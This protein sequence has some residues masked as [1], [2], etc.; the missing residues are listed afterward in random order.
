MRLVLSF[1]LNIIKNKKI[2]IFLHTNL[3]KIS[4]IVEKFLI[5][6]YNNIMW[7]RQKLKVWLKP[8]SALRRERNYPMLLKAQEGRKTFR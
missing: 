5:L 3:L 7:V 1:L 4:K 2:S 6:N 8:L